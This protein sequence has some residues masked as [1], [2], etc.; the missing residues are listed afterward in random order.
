M[1]IVS[2]G[3][4]CSPAS[5]SAEVEAGE[6]SAPLDTMNIEQDTQQAPMPAQ[7]DAGNLSD[8]HPAS[9]VR[10]GPQNGENFEEWNMR[11]YTEKRRRLVIL[12]K[13]H[14]ETFQRSG[15][16][17]NKLRSVEDE[18]DRV[19]GEF[20]RYHLAAYISKC[21]QQAVVRAPPSAASEPR[22][23][24][25]PAQFLENDED[26]VEE[27]EEIPARIV[28]RGRKRKLVIDLPDEEDEEE[29]GDYDEGKERL[30]KK[31]RLAIR[32]AVL[33]LLR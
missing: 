24:N 33:G 25:Q 1:F 8:C 2:S 4:D 31:K 26:E 5:T 22:Y 16:D 17:G 28:M 9:I 32:S 3:A 6:Q 29:M 7:L 21:V 14:N 15:R 27:Y 20:R 19:D 11:I 10:A 12:Q 23:N 18:I 30:R 13:R